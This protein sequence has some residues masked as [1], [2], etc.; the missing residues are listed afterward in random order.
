MST[1]GQYNEST[2]RKTNPIFSQLRTTI[3]S[4]FYG[5]NI[6]AIND[7]AT[8]YHLAHDA[9]E[10][11]I[12]DLPI[13]YADELG[14]PADA[15]MLVDNNGQIVGRTAAARRI[16]GHSGVD[17]AV[18][19]KIAR[20]AIYQG[21]KQTFYKTSVVVGLDEDFMLKAHLAIP[22]GFENNLLSYLLNFQAINQHY[23]KHYQ[24]STAYNEGDIF[25]YAN[26]DFQHPDFPNGLAL[27][28]PQHNVA[29]ILG[30]R[31]FGELKKATLTLAWATAHRNGYVACH[32]GEKAFHFT[33]RP[34]QVYAMFGLSG[35]G[36]STLTHAKHG[37]RFKTTV[38]HDDAFVISRK[39]G[40]SV[41][42]E[43]AYFDKTND[44]PSGTAETEYFMT[45]MNVGVTLNTA[46]QKTL[47]TEDLRNGNGRTVKSRYASTNRV[48]KE[49]A[50][51]NAIF[52]IMKDDSL[53]PVIKVSDP[54]LAATL[55]VTL[56]TKRSSAENLVGKIDRKALVIEPFADPFRAYPLKEDYSDFKSLFEEQKVA[57]YIL[58]LYFFLLIVYKW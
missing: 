12:T 49:S 32:G 38:L 54:I 46:G 20:E 25:I 2:I 6:T 18:M 14:L 35:S 9:P 11:I 10:T 36:K 4:T 37:G 53:P 52:W 43:P 29:I 42:L 3:E 30:L 5:N 21:S 28:D 13:K 31:Y 51:I 8:A 22:K 1:V 44:Y 47:V 58:A 55:G 48:D 15:V 24:A 33:D 41:A 56:A 19:A 39:N 34:D 57:C 27:F 23:A 7:V 26:P 45:L 16:L 17:T 50:P 40:S